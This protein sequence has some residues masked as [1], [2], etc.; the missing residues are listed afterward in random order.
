M[1]AALP[2]DLMVVVCVSPGETCS[3]SDLMLARILPG[4]AFELL[5]AAAW[6]D[7]LGYLPGEIS[8]KFL[9]ELMPL[10]RP[11]TSEF[12]ASLLDAADSP[13]LDVTLWCKDR[14]HKRFRFHRRRDPYDGA[15]FVLADELLEERRELLAC[16]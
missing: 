16:N 5:S 11:T 12:V 15:T 8:G 3:R 1:Q 14:R 4:G 10:E 9:H 6:A 7:A 2:A 13:P